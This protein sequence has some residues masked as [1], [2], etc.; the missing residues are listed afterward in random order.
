MTSASPISA[1]EV[2]KARDLS[3]TGPL[4]IAERRSRAAAVTFPDHPRSWLAL[5]RVTA[6]QGRKELELRARERA[7]YCACGGQAPQGPWTALAAQIHIGHGRTDH[8]AALA[9]QALAVDPAA[10][11]VWR[12]LIK[13]AP[14]H[15]RALAT[16]RAALC[17]MPERAVLLAESAALYII[18]G[19]HQAARRAGDRYYLLSPGGRDVAKAVDR[20]LKG[21]TMGERLYWSV[22]LAERHP[23]VPMPPRRDAPAITSP[24]TRDQPSPRYHVLID[25]YRQMHDQ[26]IQ[27][28]HRVFAGWTSLWKV[29]PALRAFIAGLGP[30]DTLLDYGGGRSEQYA[31]A[32]S[33]PDGTAYPGLAAFLGVGS[34]HCWDPGHNRQDL[35]PNARFD[36]VISIDVLE[37][38]DRADLPWIVADL[39]ARARL[40]VFAQ[41]ACYRA[42]KHLPNGENCHCTVKPPDWWQALFAAT[43]TRFPGI[44]YRVLT[45]AFS[46]ATDFKTFGN[47]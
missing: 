29:L 34:V 15:R 38:C 11:L 6:G 8:A 19:A 46:L 2:V 12:L 20:A 44:H 31:S 13:T 35:D 39:F 33:L 26:A 45:S 40:G 22:Y 25:Q 42:I 47:S 5:A 28:N 17:V 32:L 24:F 30:V 36:V 23:P 4:T 21:G 9:R 43:A 41:I 37:H 18:I 16:L 27:K 10:P 3:L 7:L 1:R 14:D